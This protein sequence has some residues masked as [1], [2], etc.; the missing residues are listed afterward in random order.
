MILSSTFNP[1]LG[2]KSNFSP[3]F[4]TSLAKD[5]F[6]K[7]TSPFYYAKK[8]HKAISNSYK[9]TEKHYMVQPN[10]Q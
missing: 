6:F 7:L 3:I 8:Y 9:I 5:F 2:L 1:L 4:P 10:G